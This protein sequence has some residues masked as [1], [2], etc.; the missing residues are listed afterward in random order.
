MGTIIWF[1]TQEMDLGPLDQ[2][3]ASRAFVPK[4]GLKPPYK[5]IVMLVIYVN[6]QYILSTMHGFRGL[7]YGQ[8]RKKNACMI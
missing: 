1:L 2:N 8:Q 5:V 3:E 6:N 7:D 4:L